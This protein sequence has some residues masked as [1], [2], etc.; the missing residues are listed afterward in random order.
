V[1]VKLR[2]PPPLHALRWIDWCESEGSLRRVLQLVLLFPDLR[3]G[4]Y[5]FRQTKSPQ[6]I[7]TGSSSR[8]CQLECTGREQRVAWTTGRT[9]PHKL[10]MQVPCVPK[11]LSCSKWLGQGL[12]LLEHCNLWL[13][14]LVTV[15]LVH[16]NIAKPCLYYA[17]DPNRGDCLTAASW[18][19]LSEPA[20]CSESYITTLGHLASLSC[21]EG[22]HVGPMTKFLLLSDICWFH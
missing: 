12:D 19:G 15:S 22:T 4:F 10:N 1:W 6:R 3:A 21:C 5:C 2:G 14:V 18:T 8:R 9:S 16:Y 7:W 17:V 11:I 20:L 13:Q